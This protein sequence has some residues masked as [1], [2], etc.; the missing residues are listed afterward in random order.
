[1]TQPKSATSRGKEDYL[2]SVNQENAHKHKAEDFHEG[3]EIYVWKGTFAGSTT[4]VVT[5]IDSKAG[6]VEI[7]F[8]NNKSLH[9]PAPVNL[10][11]YEIMHI[12]EFKVE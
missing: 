5:A 6:T 3:E 11:P 12:G 10:P 4:G 9:A 1:M 7:T 2:F 8:E